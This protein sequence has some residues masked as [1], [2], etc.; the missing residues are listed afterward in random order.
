LF[1]HGIAKNL[2]E[3]ADGAGKDWLRAEELVGASKDECLKLRMRAKLALIRKEK[4]NLVQ[5]FYTNAM[6]LCQFSSLQYGSGYLRDLSVLLPEREDI[7]KMS[8]WLEE[9][10]SRP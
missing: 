5:E 10:L 1:W 3:D 9:R 8:K 2:L 4:I 6:G 7:S